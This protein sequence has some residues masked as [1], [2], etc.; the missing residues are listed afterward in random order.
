MTNDKKADQ[1][2]KEMELANAA[3]LTITNGIEI[4]GMEEIPESIIP[5]PFVRL[6]QPTSTKISMADGKEAPVGTFYFNDTRRCE[7]TL[8]VALLKGKHAKV[9]YERDGEKTPTQKLGILAQ[10]T[11]SGKLLILSL[12]V[13]SFSNYGKLM[14]QMKEEKVK[15]AWERKV[16]ISSDKQENEKGKYYI[17]SFELKEEFPKEKQEELE[18]IYLKH[19]DVFNKSEEEEL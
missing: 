15:S 3:D 5:I 4:F 19:K 11:K 10:E 1:F 12:S 18:K 17:A 8:E 13:M 7:E 6:V 2:E 16:V 14:A 9:V